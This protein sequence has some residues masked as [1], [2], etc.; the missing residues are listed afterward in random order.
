MNQTE[1]IN[2]FTKK[3]LALTFVLSA[4][5]FAFGQEK[6]GVSGT[7]V[8]KSN[9]PVPYASV[10]FSHKQNK[11]FSD[12]TLTDEKGQYRLE[13]T[14]GNYDVSVEAIDYKKSTINKQIAAA[15]NIGALSIE[16]EASTTNLKTQDI[17]GVTITAT[18][19]PYKVELD[20]RTYDPSQDIVSKGGNL[21][22]VLSN[23][24]SVSVDTDGTVSMR[25]SSN[26]RFL[27][28]GKPSALLGIDDGANALQSI[29]ADQIERIEVITNPSSKFEASGTAG[30]LNIILKKSKKTGFNGSVT[31]TLGYLPQTNL[32]TNLSW[33][34][35]NLTW[36]LN[37]GGGYRESKNTNRNNATYFNAV[38]DKDR[39]AINQESI[40]NNNN[41][42]YNASSGFVYD[43]S[44]KTSI[45]ASAT[46][47]TFDS[48]NIGN[49]TYDERFK[50]GT[51]AF[52]QRLNN[53]S[54][55]NLAFQGDFGLDH[56]FDDKG[57]L[58]SLSAS[59]QS[60][61]SFNDTY[62][63]QT[64]NGLYELENSINQTTKNKTLVGKADYELPIG[65]NAKIEAGYR[66]DINQNVYDNDVLERT[67]AN[68]VFH[69]LN[70]YTYNAYYREIFNAGYVQF[71]S[72]IGK[73]GYQL[74]LRNE[75]SQVDIKYSNLDYYTDNIN[76]KKTYNNLFPSV[77]LSYE[78]AKDN[79]FLINYSRRIDRPRS[80]FLIPNPSYTD[81]Q[82]IFEGN[83]D[84]NPSY[85][86]S[87]EFGYSI[88]KGKFTIN[89][90]LYY[91]HSTDDV[92]M[93]VY[94]DKGVFKTRP[95]NLGSDDRYGLDLNF[96]WD[97]TKW[98]K[99]LGNVDLF[100]YKTTGI[101]TDPA[102]LTKPMSFEGTGFST[103][104]RLTSTFK[105]DKTFSFQLQGFYRGA[106]K[107][108]N[109]TRNDM[110]ALNL[111]AS[112]T[113]WDG[114]GTVSFNIQD[115]FNTR[116]MR[117]VTNTAEFSRDSYMQW[118]PRQ[119]AV[120]LTYRF[121]Q[122]EKIEQPKKKKDVNSNATGDEQQ[123]PM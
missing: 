102:I 87:Y 58:I 100:G 32:N 61:R 22:D 121:K 79:Q 71:R 14:P 118:Q 36:F 113:I 66:L 114:N 19:K 81:N 109:Q 117:S 68:P 115:I 47:R 106:Q 30:I 69:F 104:A 110:Y 18:V 24:P 15:G 67:V 45:N 9:Q 105:I 96:N 72:K 90:T 28:N 101:Y 12:A 76:S 93:L 95:I 92:K 17:Q 3:T 112:K 21:Q 108:E 116:S 70:N 10:T 53:G 77:F 34:K 60:N 98:L 44:D 6:V 123:A 57:Q 75:Y 84:L 107:T 7:I 25:G 31:G 23:V 65:E 13:L 91:R 2:I 46:V 97:A 33:R 82:N 41:N 27:I 52:S 56:K 94:S 111:G 54:N 39:T 38:A 73:L 1:I 103:R 40:S 86:D 99:F 49:V 62:V 64:Q 85:V 42:N 51:G 20:K 83:I 63:N 16:A 29:P 35:G 48:E 26:V 50:D 55:D 59:L 43:F 120:S 11:L 80:F 4:A 37:G 74:G 119:F 88:S 8:D 89:P 78:I 5:A 122:G